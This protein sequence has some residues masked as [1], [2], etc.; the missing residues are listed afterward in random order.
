[1]W[2]VSRKTEISKP[3]GAKHICCFNFLGGGVFFGLCYFVYSLKYTWLPTSDSLNT[4]AIDGQTWARYSPLF[5]AH[6]SFFYW[7]LQNWMIILWNSLKWWLNSFFEI[8]IYMIFLLTAC[9]LAN[10]ICITFFMHSG[11]LQHIIVFL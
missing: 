2:D 3:L 5:T 8:Y 1:M 11:L 4:I 6:I 7:T 9:P 10:Y